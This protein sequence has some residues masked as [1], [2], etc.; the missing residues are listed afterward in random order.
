MEVSHLDHLVL[1]V[2]DI[3]RTVRFYETVLGMKKEVFGNGRVALRFGRQ[4]INVHQVG[5][6]MEPKAG[7]VSV[8]SADVCF[9]VKTPLSEAKVHLENLGVSIC[10]GPVQR[11][12]AMGNNMVSLYFRDPDQNLIE[13]ANYEKESE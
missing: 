11:I 5:D 4:K 3:A 2:R 7:N 10:S 6:E 13:I 12:G 9:I 1:T 8:G